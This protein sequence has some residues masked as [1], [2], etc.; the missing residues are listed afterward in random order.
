MS[1]VDVD[2]W[3]D[4]F[5]AKVKVRSQE[6]DILT[7]IHE[8][9]HSKFEQLLEGPRET[10]LENVREFLRERIRYQLAMDNDLRLCRNETKNCRL[11]NPNDTRCKDL[12]DLCVELH[13][14][15]TQVLPWIYWREEEFLKTILT[16]DEYEGLRKD[17][18]N[19]LLL[20]SKIGDREAMT[21]WG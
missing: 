17:V 9:T 20:Y 7:K 6:R 19:D 3:L 5:R 11:K 8:S 15:S 12:S 18:I 4:W 1:E 16:P 14:I 21:F 13:K 2:M 10:L